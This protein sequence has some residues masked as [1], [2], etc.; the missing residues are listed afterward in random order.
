MFKN[1]FIIFF[2]IL[3]LVSCWWDESTV[4]I[5]WLKKIDNNN[6]SIFIPDNW[7]VM[8]N[9]DNILPKPNFWQIEFVVSSNNS[10]NWFRNNMLILSNE[11]NEFTTSKDFSMLN[12]IWA[13]RDYFNYTLLEKKDFLFNDGEESLVYIFEAKYNNDSPKIKFIQTSHICNQ[14]KAYFFTIAL[15]TSIKDT[16]K[17]EQLIQTFECKN[18]INTSL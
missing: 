15:P 8:E 16:L 2:L 3:F 12:N 13:E 9:T 7:N 1:F 5:E 6:F 18:I 11:L 4:N 10:I 14:K 17:Y